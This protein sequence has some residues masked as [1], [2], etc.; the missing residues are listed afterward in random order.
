MHLA[1]AYSVSNT[2]IS[3]CNAYSDL[4]IMWKGRRT[5]IQS[6]TGVR[7]VGE[8]GD[9]T[10]NTRRMLSKRRAITLVCKTAEA[11]KHY[12]VRQAG[13]LSTYC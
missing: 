6:Q 4:T 5:D 1:F 13:R 8:Y 3:C 7:G 12:P 10:D 11:S 9:C 2:T